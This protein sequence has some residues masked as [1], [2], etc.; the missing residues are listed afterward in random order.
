MLL[1]GRVGLISG[2]GPG[3]GR[4]IALRLAREGADVVLLARS[5]GSSREIAAE[6]EALGRRALPLQA[7]ITDP[8][9]CATALERTLAAFGRVDVLVNNAFTTGPMQPIEGTNIMSAW[10][11]PFKVNVFG[12]LQ[13]SQ[14]VA[15]AMKT[16]KEG[17]IVMV[18]SLAA[19]QVTR[20]LAAYGASKAALLYATKA[21][22]AELGAHGVRVNSVVPGH[23]EGPSLDVYIQMEAQRLAITEDR[24]RE[25]IAAQGVLQRIATPE[26]VASAVLFFASELSSAITGQA[27]DVNCGQWFN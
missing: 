10:R 17:T 27:L 3:L 15:G 12:T 6:V 21:L 24:A 20:D 19:R 16:Q 22:A 25:Q 11:A 7:D 18:N 14:V 26:Q 9:A 5:E 8:D 1:S 2:V 23:I 4:A 13:L